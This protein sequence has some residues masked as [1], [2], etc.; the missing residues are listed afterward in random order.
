MGHVLGMKLAAADGASGGN[1]RAVPIGEAMRRLDFSHRQGSMQRAYP[2][3]RCSSSRDTRANARKAVMRSRS[4]LL[5]LQA[6]GFGFAGSE[7]EQESF[8]QRGYGR[9]PLGTDHASPPVGLV[10]K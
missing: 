8:Y 2:S 4:A 6:L 10:V 3:R 5:A 9:V 1:D 7:L